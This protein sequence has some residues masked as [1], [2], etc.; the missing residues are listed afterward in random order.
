MI[1][2]VSTGKGNE[3]TKWGLQHSWAFSGNMQL[4]DSAH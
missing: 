2:T 4:L 3:G 1:F